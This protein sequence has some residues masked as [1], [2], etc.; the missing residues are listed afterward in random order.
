[1]KNPLP[2]YAACFTEPSDAL[3]DTI[4]RHL[5]QLGP[6]QLGRE[7]GQLLI[8]AEKALRVLSPPP[9]NTADYKKLYLA[10][11]QRYVRDIEEAQGMLRELNDEVNAMSVRVR[12]GSLRHRIEA[13]LKEKG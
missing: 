9:A 3:A 2:K 8:Q 5:R 6:H 12:D 7:G 13:Y 10:C 4:A 1:M 11:S